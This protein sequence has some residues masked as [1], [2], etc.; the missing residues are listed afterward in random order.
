MNLRKK[1]ALA[2]GIMLV[3]LMIV[4]GT[5]THYSIKN[6]FDDLQQQDVR[7]DIGRAT[8]ALSAD[9]NIL[10]SFCQ[11]TADRETTKQLIDN[12]NNKIAAYSHTSFINTNLDKKF[13]FACIFN[14]RGEIVF[15]EAIDISSGRAISFPQ[16]IINMTELG[17]VSGEAFA[18]SGIIILPESPAI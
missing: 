8:N 17:N 10:S 3:L 4:M 13:N 11:V 15:K 16:S 12:Y 1:T 2:M 18:K 5:I 7:K 6:A 14:N 9:I